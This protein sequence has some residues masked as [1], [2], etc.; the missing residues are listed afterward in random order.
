MKAPFVKIAFLFFA[1]TQF[2]IAQQNEFT[3]INYSPDYTTE[4]ILI[5]VND[6]SFR[7]VTT[8]TGEEKIVIAPN[9]TP[10]LKSGAPDLPKF[11]RSLIIP[12]LANMEVEILSD[13]YIDYENVSIAASFGNLSR[14]SQPNDYDRVKSS[15]Y[16]QNEFY[17][18]QIA[19]LRNPYILSDFRAITLVIQPFQYNPVTRVLRVHTQMSVRLKQNSLAPI[20]PF[21]R[22]KPVEV[23]HEKAKIYSRHLLNYSS[24]RYTALDEDGE[25]LI[26]AH[27][28]FMNAMIP[29]IDWKNE[30]GL[31]TTMVN[32]VDIGN[33][34][35]AIKNYITNYYQNHNLSYVILVGDIAQV[36]SPSLSGGKSDP[37][38]GYILGNDSYPEVIIGR[39]SAE[40]EAHVTTQIQKFITYEKTP[41]TSAFYTNTMG[42]ASN[43]GPGDDDEMDW[44]HMRNM[45]DKLLAYT[46]NEKFEF[47]D[48][49]QGEQDAAGNPTPSTL[50]PALNAGIGLI[51]YCGHGS[52]SSWGSSGFDN[53]DINQLS[54]TNKLPL[55]WSVA[56]VNGEFDNG[57]CFGEA[58]LRSNNNGN[59][60]GAAGAFMSS[61]NQSWNPPMAAQDEMIDILTENISGVNTRTFG[62]ISISGCLKMND[63][64]GA[65][66]AE[67]TD[68]WHIFGDPTL[69]VRTAQPS[70][71]QVNHAAS[72][73]LGTTQFSVNVNVEDALVAISQ[74]G[75][76]LG[77]ANVAGSN[78][79]I[80]FEAINNLD[81]LTVTVSAFNHIPYQGKVAINQ[82][83]SAFVVVN[84]API[85]DP[86]GNQN[87]LA[88]YNENVNL[89][90]ALINQGGTPTGEILATVSTI[91]EGITLISNTCQIPSI[92]AG[93]SFDIASCIQF[94][95]SGEIEDQ[96]EV[97]FDI[98]ITDNEGNEWNNTVAVTIQAPRIVINGYEIS[99]ALGNNNNRLDAGESATISVNYKNIGHSKAFNGLGSI[100]A[101]S[102]ISPLSTT[103]S[104]VDLDVNSEGEISLSFQVN[105]STPI[106]SVVTFNFQNAF[107]FYSTNLSIIEKIGLIVEDAESADF[108]QIPWFNESNIPWEIDAINKYQGDNSFVSGN[109][110]DNETSEL[111]INYTTSVAD[112]LSFV[113]KISSED[114]YDFL[115]FYVDE[116]LEA[117]WSGNS[118]WLQEK[119]A[120]VQGEHTF[121]WVYQK[122]D[123]IS[124]GEDAA[125]IDWIV[126]PTGNFTDN[127]SGITTSK[128]Q[129]LIRIY[130]NPSNG[131]FTLSISATQKEVFNL[132]IIDLSGRVVDKIDNFKVFDGTN[133]TTF[134][135][136]ASI[137]NGYYFLQLSSNKRI[138]CEK[139]SVFR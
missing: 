122:D 9:A 98:L 37:S 49:S 61:I 96:T 54:N 11:S 52:N 18:S 75:V 83:T 15:V 113:R 132:S 14:T 94:V 129:N 31:K 6:F 86:L 64:Y 108:S 48:G 33:A 72:T 62:G 35:T 116:E 118:D 56:C 12:D 2:S 78:A 30:K 100:S 80:N 28:P 16:Q 53:S 70:A 23:T 41:E 131:A 92:A 99:D 66:G 139:I 117:E 77:K 104:L 84:A 112:T 87:Q 25:L 107:G 79:A 126:F 133:S 95:V 57:T 27:G 97:N 89:G 22:T 42:V 13:E 68:T 39:I 114:G 36:A 32:V 44:E 71:L 127:T 58:W 8:A 106:G 51:N 50:L 7:N 26:I 20:N 110:S 38:Y 17:P 105:P 119:F 82:P 34:S 109:I 93:G 45:Q 65:A 55:I 47:Y 90:L 19:S 111:T 115:K 101:T 103:Q 102:F 137:A 24:A 1:F 124:A 63:E 69:M 46:Y 73:N 10:I 135:V 91:S 60:T 125:W 59:L 21:Y 121:K 3:L 40:S 120:I 81:S 123:M 43:E 67:M 74:N 29:F 5:S 76:L 85:N 128:S 4:D 134:Q 138:M 130:P 136:P 88:D